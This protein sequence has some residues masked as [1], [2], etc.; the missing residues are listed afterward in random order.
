MSRFESYAQLTTN[1]TAHLQAR[2]L[3]QA[4][5]G[6]HHGHSGHAEAPNHACGAW[7]AAA[8]YAAAGARPLLHHLVPQAKQTLRV[9]QST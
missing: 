8:V 1:F 4:V 6:V 5:L 3:V 9:T 7:W 2:K